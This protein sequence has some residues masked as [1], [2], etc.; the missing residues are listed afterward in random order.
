MRIDFAT[1]EI[2]AFPVKL[3]SGIVDLDNLL[4]ETRILARIFK[5]LK[6]QMGRVPA[7]GYHFTTFCQEAQKQAQ[8]FK[9]EPSQF[10]VIVTSGGE[11]TPFD[12]SSTITLSVSTGTNEKPE[13][14]TTWVWKKGYLSETDMA[15]LSDSWFKVLC[16]IAKLAETPELGGLTPSNIDLVRLS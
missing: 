2:S 3:D 11:N 10:R 14:H 16:G 13:L 6:E 9:L 4:S 8:L 15:K 1:Q 7:K 12:S 5:R